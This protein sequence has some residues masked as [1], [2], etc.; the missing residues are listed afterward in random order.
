MEG[1][2]ANATVH[3]S[4]V[5]T[6]RE[7]KGLLGGLG[8]GQAVTAVSPDCFWSSALAESSVAEGGL[9]PLQLSRTLTPNTTAGPRGFAFN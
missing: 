8:L 9:S 2:S 3:F 6:F 5:I 4:R 7:T 1:V